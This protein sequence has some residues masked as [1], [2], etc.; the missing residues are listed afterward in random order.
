MSNGRETFIELCLKGE[1]KIEDI[2]DFVDQWH[3]SEV[4]ES[5]QVYLGMD[6]QEYG[7]WLTRPD[8]L[9]EILSSRR[10]HTDL[11]VTGAR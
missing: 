7:L 10:N 9:P 6:D 3:D 8:R 2:D 11:G 1:V 5:L 4:P